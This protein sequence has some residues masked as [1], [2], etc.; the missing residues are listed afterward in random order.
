MTLSFRWLGVSGIEIVS[1]GKVLLVDPFL[2]RIPLRK[3]FFGRIKS[4]PEAVRALG[5]YDCL[6]VTHSH[7]DHLLD[8]PSLKPKEGAEIIGSPNTRALLATLGVPGH[9]IQTVGPG[10][11]LGCG[12]F[13]IKVFASE[14]APVPGYKSGRL[15]RILE[16]PFKAR[17]YRMDFGCAY[18]IS[19]GG[20]SFLTDP[21]M[22]PS[23]DV[24]ADVLFT[25][26]FHGK[27]YY[28]KLIGIVSPKVIVPVHWDNLFSR[29]APKPYF[30]PPV[31]GWP[32]VRR[33]NLRAFL[34]SIRTISPSI[35]VIIP[36]AFRYY[37]V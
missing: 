20:S 2:T 14:H 22:D 10:D 1:G 27:G 6:L 32:P 17:D 24:Q 11:E 16:P 7:F 36:E 21:G 26:P 12:N 9:R 31:S 15:P 8:V 5:P 28:E 23:V 19:A 4:D 13:K 18:H 29:G 25:Q 34:E 30:S 37:E 3:T 35:K 33:I